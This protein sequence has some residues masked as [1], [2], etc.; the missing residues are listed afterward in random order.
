MIDLLTLLKVRYSRYESLIKPPFSGLSF[1]LQ[2]YN[3]RIELGLL[4]L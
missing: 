4:F 3:F 1:N 2:T